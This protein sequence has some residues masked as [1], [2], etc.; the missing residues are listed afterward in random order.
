MERSY[1]FVPATKH[2]MISKA[3]ESKADAIIIDLEDSVAYLEKEN[4][5]KACTCNRDE[6]EKNITSHK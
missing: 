1:L 2:L 5:D 3:L 4:V 6:Q